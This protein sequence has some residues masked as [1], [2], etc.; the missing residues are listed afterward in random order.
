M[1]ISNQKEKSAQLRLADAEN[2]D[3]CEHNA[4]LH[5]EV[6]QLQEENAHM[7]QLLHITPQQN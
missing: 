4:R 2:S 5:S 1:N 3:L 7:R 6:I